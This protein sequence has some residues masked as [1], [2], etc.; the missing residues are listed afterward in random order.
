MFDLVQEQIKD[1]KRKIAFLSSSLKYSDQID[2]MEGYRE[3]L[4]THDIPFDETLVSNIVDD[5]ETA[6]SEMLRL[7]PQHNPDGVVTTSELAALGAQEALWAFD[8]KYLR[9]V[10]VSALGVDTWDQNSNHEGRFV[11]RRRALALGSEAAELL[12]KQINE[13]RIAEISSQM[14]S[15]GKPLSTNFSSVQYLS[16]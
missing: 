10:S 6:F 15:G 5:K 4:K 11:S 3:A 9:E 2:A 7:I 8:S 13:P 1:G 16:H 12:F 14:V